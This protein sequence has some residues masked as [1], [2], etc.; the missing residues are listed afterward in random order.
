MQLKTDGGAKLGPQT[1]PK[2]A[3]RSEKNLFLTAFAAV[4][5]HD[6]AGALCFLYESI[7]VDKPW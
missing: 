1:A 3:E 7:S 4:W 5:G 6:S 2:A